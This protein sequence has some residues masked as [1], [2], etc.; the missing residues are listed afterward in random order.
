MSKRRK[1]TLFVV[2][3]NAVIMAQI[4]ALAVLSVCGYHLAATLTTAAICL[5]MFFWTW[6]SPQKFPVFG[7]GSSLCIFIA[8]LSGLSLY[9]TLVTVGEAFA[10]GLAFSILGLTNLVFFDCY[11]AYD[12]LDLD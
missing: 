9:F 12:R 1:R 3:L 2:L 7:F 11:Y 4:V 5:A 10:V 8:S 6:E